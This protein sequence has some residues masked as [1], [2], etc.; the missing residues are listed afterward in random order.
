M[1]SA[2]I[3]TALGEERTSRFEISP[4]GMAL[5]FGFGFGFCFWLWLLLLALAFA[6]GSWLLASGSSTVSAAG[7]FD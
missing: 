7:D 6:F 2:E 5:G 4:A 1:S 3:W